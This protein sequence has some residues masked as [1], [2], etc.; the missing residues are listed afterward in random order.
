[1]LGRHHAQTLHGLMGTHCLLDSDHRNW[2]VLTVRKTGA[3]VGPIFI[4]HVSSTGVLTTSGVVCVTG[5]G[6]AATEVLHIHCP[7]MLQGG[8]VYAAF[9]RLA[10]KEE[11]GEESGMVSERIARA[12]WTDDHAVY[13]AEL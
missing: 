12:A 9:G 7:W 10:C 13:V 4:T 8:W 1:M 6:G 2:P 3:A 5:G 11:S